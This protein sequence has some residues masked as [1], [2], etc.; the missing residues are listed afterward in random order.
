MIEDLFTAILFY[1]FLIT[2]VMSVP[3][4]IV[5]LTIE[6]FTRWKRKAKCPSRNWLNCMKLIIGLIVG[7][8]RQAWITFVSNMLRN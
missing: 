5:A 2:I 3:I 4:M 1:G 7:R 8:I 6:L